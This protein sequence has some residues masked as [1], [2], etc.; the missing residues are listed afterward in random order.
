M[1][2]DVIVIDRET[3]GSGNDDVGSTLLG[4]VLRKLL[5]S[6]KKPDAIVFYNSGVKLV[7]KGSKYIDILNALEEY[8]VELIV[9]GTCVFE[10][11]KQKSLLAGRISDMDEISSILIGATKVWSL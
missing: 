4:V 5:A 3:L 7:V 2:K 10:V 8:G 9:C 6:P 11:C 1:Y